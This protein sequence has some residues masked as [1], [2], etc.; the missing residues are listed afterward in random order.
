MASTLRFKTEC[1]FELRVRSFEPPQIGSLRA[2]RVRMA[3]TPNRSRMP[4]MR[5]KGF[6]TPRMMVWRPKRSRGRSMFVIDGD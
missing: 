4:E 5:R 1:L 6:P 3:P 2:A